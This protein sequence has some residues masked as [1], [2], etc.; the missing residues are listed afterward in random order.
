MTA[1]HHWRL[2]MF[3]GLEI[4]VD[5]GR[6]N[7]LLLNH[8]KYLTVSLI[9][10]LSVIE[11]ILNQNLWMNEFECRLL[12]NHS[13]HY[14]TK[15]HACVPWSWMLHGISAN[16]RP[17]MKWYWVP[18][19]GRMGPDFGTFTQYTKPQIWFIEFTDLNLLTW[20]IFWVVER[21]G[22]ISHCAK[23]RCAMC[24]SPN[25]PAIALAMVK[26]LSRRIGSLR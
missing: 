19:M 12:T 26:Y 3:Y 21:H 24:D 10:V 23:S 22:T 11:L 25:S 1:V 13:I 14:P 6:T 2:D 18:V 7:S 8:S 20:S 4:S 5:E 15:E 9:F 17:W 16:T